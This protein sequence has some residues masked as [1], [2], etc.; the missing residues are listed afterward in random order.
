MR[1]I[2]AIAAAVLAIA[3]AAAASPAAG[4]QLPIVQFQG[5]Y[6]GSLPYINWAW[7][8]TP[9]QKCLETQP[10]LRQRA[11]GART[12][13]SHRLP[14]RQPRRL[15]QQRGGPKVRAARRGAWVRG[16]GLQLRQLADMGLAGRL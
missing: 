7:W 5:T 10:F 6:S 14:T 16:R 2:M 11:R 3:P 15:G 8:L 12:V 1:R 9:S 4:A 13:S